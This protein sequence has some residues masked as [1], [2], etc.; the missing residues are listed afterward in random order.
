MTYLRSKEYQAISEHSKIDLLTLLQSLHHYKSDTEWD[1]WR[2]D[3]VL[4]NL[5]GK[6]VAL[7][8]AFPTN[9]EV[10]IDDKDIPRPFVF[11]IEISGELHNSGLCFFS[12]ASCQKYGGFAAHHPTLDNE[13]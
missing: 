10:G 6:K 8:V 11:K 9:K 4:T 3:A 12:E 7:I 1:Y 5:E 13:H 2:L